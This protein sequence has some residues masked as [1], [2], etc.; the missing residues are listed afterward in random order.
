MGE[1]CV[2]SMIIDKINKENAKQPA[3]KKLTMQEVKG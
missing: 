2:L 3:N 1:K